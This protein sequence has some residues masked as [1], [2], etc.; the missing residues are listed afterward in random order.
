MRTW[1]R[2]LAQ[3][4]RVAEQPVVECWEYACVPAA[5]P[6]QRVWLNDR[7]AWCAKGQRYWYVAEYRTLRRGGSLLAPGTYQSTRQQYDRLSTL[8]AAQQRAAEWAR[9]RA[10][11]SAKVT[12]EE[13]LVCLE[14]D[15]SM[16]HEPVLQEPGWTMR[17][18]R[19]DLAR[20]E[21]VRRLAR[22]NRRSS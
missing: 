13:P 20:I 17:L 14:E 10:A 6:A 1:L 8:E 11:S 3:R 7:M 21:H 4:A 5:N 19:E 22:G 18:G 9:Q 16:H 2:R 12:R 15:H